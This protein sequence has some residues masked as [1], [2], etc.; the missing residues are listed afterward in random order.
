MVIPQRK[1][2]APL[3]H[4]IKNKLLVFTVLPSKHI[5]A[6][7]HRRVKSAPAIG[8]EHIL[9]D[10]LNV[11]SAEHLRRSIIPRALSSLLEYPFRGV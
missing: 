9:D 6:L 11:F 4:Q 2:F 10:T 8:R 5:L 7:K 1:L 3:I